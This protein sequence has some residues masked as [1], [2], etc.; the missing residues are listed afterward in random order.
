M[1]H[2]S[3]RCAHCEESLEVDDLYCPACGRKA[4]SRFCP[5]C[6]G[7]LEADDLFCPACG[8]GREGEAPEPSER[9]EGDPVLPS[10]HVGSP[11]VLRSVLL[12]AAAWAAGGFVHG[13]GRGGPG[14][15]LL[16]GALWFA[17]GLVAGALT[18]RALV[19]VR[20]TAPLPALLGAALGWI[21]LLSLG[22]QVHRAIRTLDPPY[23]VGDLLRIGLLSAVA[24]AAGGWMVRQIGLSDS[25]ASQVP[26][27]GAALGW[28]AGAAVAFL[29]QLAL[30]TL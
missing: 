5:S 27:A 12:W 16:S 11:E 10:S 4:P 25:P 2:G 24:A 23:L 30:F 8:R 15:A 7:P 28:G 13:L 6:G 20:R 26:I 29:L 9:P 21:F 18:V 1:G 3:M 17:G 22:P 19:T 14:P